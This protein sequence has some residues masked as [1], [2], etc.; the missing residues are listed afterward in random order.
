MTGVQTCA[1]PILRKLNSVPGARSSMS[2]TSTSTHDAAS[3]TFP[4]CTIWFIDAQS[5]DAMPRP[6]I[7][8]EAVYALAVG[9]GIRIDSTYIPRLQWARLE[10]RATERDGPES[11]MRF[12]VGSTGALLLIPRDGA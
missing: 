7:G 4:D 2:W 11:P 1:L 3:F 5:A 10:S 9:G 6:V 8:A 12:D